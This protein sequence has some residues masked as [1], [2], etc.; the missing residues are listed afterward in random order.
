MSGKTRPQILVARTCTLRA[1]TEGQPISR[2]L[3]DYR[4]VSAYV[5]LGDPGAGKTKSFEQ[6]ASAS[7]GHYIKA[8]DFAELEPDLAG[9]VLFIDGLDEMRAGASDGRTPL[10]E[11]RRHLK[12]LGSPS[13]RLSCR[14]ADWFGDSDRKALEA[15]APNGEIKVLH[16]D[17]LSDD[18]VRYLLEHKFAV[19]DSETFVQDAERSGLDS[20]LHN[21]QTLELMVEA[22]AGLE[23]PDSRSGV[24]E[25][26]CRKL[27]REPNEEHQTARRTHPP[28]DEGLLEAAGFL[29]AVQLLAGLA[30]VT[31]DENAEDKGFAVLRTLTTTTLSTST[32]QVATGTRL[33]Q[34]GDDEQ[35]RVF[36]HRSIAEFLG[37]RYLRA[38]IEIDGL[39]V[40]RAIA[41]LAGEDG[42]VVPELRGLAAWLAAHCRTAREVLIER[43]PLGIVLYGD[44]SAFTVED[45]VRVLSALKAEA[46]RY[47][48]FRSEDWTAAPFGALSSRDMV[49]TFIRLLETPASTDADMALLDC[50]LDAL[51]WGPQFQQIASRDEQYRLN[52]QLERIARN[53][54]NRAD[55]R[56]TALDILMRDLEAN[57]D[58]LIAFVRDA[59]DGQVTDD[60]DELTGR[61]LTRLFPNHLDPQSVF[62][63][64][65]PRKRER[66]IGAYRMFW[67]HHLEKSSP[68]SVLPE[69]LDKM[70]AHRK[71][72]RE[73]LPELEAERMAGRLLARAL[74]IHG[75]RID[76][77][78]LHDWLGTGLDKHGVGRVER[79]AQQRIGQW[80]KARP[81]RYK[82]VLIEAEKAC[83]DPTDFPLS[84][85]RASW[86]LYEADAPS[87]S[88][89]WL[90]Q[91]AVD[92]DS[93]ALRGHY[94]SETV[95]YLIAQGG[96][97]WPTLEALEFLDPWIRAYPE[98][99]QILRRFTSWELDDWRCQQA[100]WESNATVKRTLRQSTMRTALRKHIDDIR[101][102]TAPQAILNQLA[103]A[104]LDLYSD[105][106]GETPRARLA[107]LFGQD[108]E[109][110]EAAYQ[111]FRRTL[112]RDDLPMVTEIID[113][114]TKGRMHFVRQPCLVGMT[115]FF[116]SDPTAALDLD[117]ALLSRLVAFR[118]T[119]GAELPGDWLDALIA[120]RPASVADVLAHYALALL[121]AGRD[122]LYGI[123]R[124]GYGD[125]NM[126]ELARCAVPRMLEGFPL[127]ATEKQLL[128]GLDPLL[129]A[130]L[131]HLDRKVMANIVAA[132]LTKGS[133]TAAQRTYWLASGLM[134]SPDE[135]A[136][137]LKKHLGRRET[138]LGH[139][140]G[141]LAEG[142][143]WP[144]L[145]SGLSIPA[146]GMLIEMIAPNS[147][148]ERPEGVHSVTQ[149]M[150][151][152]D[153]VRGFINTLGNDPSED[154]GRELE[155]LLAQPGLTRWLGTL[156]HSIHAQRLARRKATFRR[157]DVADVCRTLV[158]REPANTADL[159]ALA[160]GH[161]QDLAKWIRHGS[162]N[163]YRQYWSYNK[164]GNP[165]HPKPEN[166][167][168]D[169]LLSDLKDRL[170]KQRVDAIKEGYYAEDKRADIRVSA[171]GAGRF[172]IPIE[173]KKD[174]HKDLWRAIR[175]QL[176]ERYTRDPGTDGF[177]IYLV[178]WFGGSGMPL[179][180]GKKPR[181]A[182]KLEEQ[183]RASLTDEEARRISVVV[184]DCAL[185][186]SKKRAPAGHCLG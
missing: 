51:L 137:K 125:E 114:E 186:A 2:P 71:D 27:V 101:K 120:A 9:K 35:K 12:R 108:D 105:I 45:K 156:R 76:D 13:F 56:A 150:Q 32:L 158:N 59:H 110:I 50:I 128:H 116:A 182:A 78:R 93:A 88:A 41:L 61:V 28:S 142:K 162:T 1:G 44:V 130:G 31:L 38:R 147:P 82:A 117:E 98:F 69:V 157:L 136:P 129:K 25:F 167:C 159:A 95:R 145:T 109:L 66:L 73:A 5:L 62:E 146:I 14:E 37:A 111:G 168:R 106:S 132:R 115:E 49:P 89:S 26:A 170:A 48:H 42:G 30:G 77:A 10:G 21:P 85:R 60:D 90:M 4:D 148:P 64:L 94:F 91:R 166:D 96:Q 169:A 185:P 17:P 175:E 107:D 126:A 164:D 113:L 29:G 151:V 124:L 70:V 138:L 80:F 161:L 123:W 141:F 133:M 119:W 19:A 57:K 100:R 178:F 104:Y 171:G 131:R 33:F 3:A 39:P 54:G 7:G 52:S 144:G 8:R 112:E 6:E 63:L 18:D 53:A 155:R 122:H 179:N 34:R 103:S 83:V 22:M 81:E 160:V 102:G 121:R 143:R 16:L 11:I 180:E 134:M 127:R 172:N 46:E 153:V 118:L 87:D 135:Y 152:A 99:E 176:I 97:S 149:A 20:L 55:V 154:A 23:R 43:D 72:L 183:L 177:G 68:D 86:C 40:G 74:E 184:I 65:H 165:E 163:D 84:L 75:D 139:L 36:V 92:A 47:E 24:Y 174:A 173:I 67:S 79:D 181:T 140:G 15:V 58:C